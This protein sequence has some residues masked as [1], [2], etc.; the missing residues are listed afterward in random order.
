MSKDK[1][2]GRAF[3]GIRIVE[4]GDGHTSKEYHAGISLRDYMATHIIG[5]LCNQIE[6]TQA[7]NFMMKVAAGVMAKLAYE[8][9]DAMLEERDK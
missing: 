9:A 4:Y 7:G 5:G 6:I 1:T 8:L 3:P 2:G